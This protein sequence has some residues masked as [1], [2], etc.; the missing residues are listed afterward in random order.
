MD[1]LVVARVLHVLGVVIWI[2]GVGIM[3][4]VILPAMATFHSPDERVRVFEAVESRFAWIARGMTLIVG[5][6]GFYMLWKFDLWE[7][8]N[9]LSFWWM[10]AMVG[11]WAVFMF[12]SSSPNRCFSIAGSWSVRAKILMARSGGCDCS[13]GFCFWRV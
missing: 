4:A 1:D 9:N 5:L 6:S 11:V 8:F 2:G 7:R 13:I 10:H 3:T 12:C